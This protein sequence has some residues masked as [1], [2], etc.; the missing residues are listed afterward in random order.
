MAPLATWSNAPT[1]S[2]EKTVARG[3][4]SVA[5]RSRRLKETSQHIANNQ[6]S[7]ATIGLPKGDEAAYPQ[8]VEDNGGDIG[9]C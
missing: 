9:L 5:A 2:T 1:A 8:A 3:L 4:A 7:N 6:R